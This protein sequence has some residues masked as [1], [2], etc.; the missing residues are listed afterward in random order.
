MHVVP[1]HPRAMLLLGAALREAGTAAESLALLTQLVSEQPHSAASR[2]ELAL[3]WIEAGRSLDAI[4]SL[5]RAVELK[6]DF[7]DAWRALGDQ[8]TAIDDTA[9]ADAAYSQ[10]I[11]ASTRDPRLLAA[12]DALCAND[13][14]QAEHRLRTHL[15]Q[16]PND[17]AALR[18]LAEVAARLERNQ[19]ARSLLERCL[20]LAPSF[21]YARHNYAVILYRLNK[22]AAALREIDDLLSLEPRNPSFRNLKAVVLA[23]VGDFDESLEIYDDILRAN[24]AHSR[25][26]M[27]YGHALAAAGRVEQ[28]IAAYRK[29]IE[30]SA[31]LGEAYW[32]LAN[33]KTFRFDDAEISAM[34]AQLKRDD[35]TDAEHLHFDFALGKALEDRG[36]YADSFEHYRRGNARRHAQVHYDPDIATSI[37]ARCKETFSREF[38]LSRAAWGF[39]AHD[40]IFIVGLPRAGSTL[41]E[42]ILASHSLIEGTMELTEIPALSRRLSGKQRRFDESRYPQ[43]LTTLGAE[44]LKAFGERYVHD[45]R[46]QRKT[47]KP[48]F[49]DKMPNNFLHIGLIALILPNAKIIDARRHPLACGF[50]CFKQ[51]FA[52]GQAFSYR[53]E[54]IGHYYRDYVELMTFFD[55]VLPGKIHRVS[56]E[57]MVENTEAET[58]QLLDYLEL[59]FESACLRFHENERAVRTASSQQVRRPIFKEGLDH[60]KHYEP[61]L[62]PLKESFGRVLD[63]YSN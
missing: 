35:L 33:L 3:T 54:D 41:I 36:H 6:P 5:R 39:A 16:F 59:P 31:N 47:S 42:Q 48:R 61:W 15:K 51:H 46:I 32:S 60:Y 55:E 27:S 10:Q 49:I 1:R 13:I 44:E 52:R 56:Y 26:W 62:L 38:F 43:V 22:P 40:P 58:R 14:P 20:E 18:M 28:S 50:S 2:Y 30:C 57:R 21:R 17:V 7:A 25:I 37:V 19:D 9:G 12:A 63:Q 8:L 23:R 45:T 24:P 29:S 4:E 34:R 53:L 11:K